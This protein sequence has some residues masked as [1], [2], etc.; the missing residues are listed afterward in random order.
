M[1]FHRSTNTLRSDFSIKWGLLL[2]LI[3]IL[4]S[5]Y[6]QVSPEE[7]KASLI[8][9]FCENV[10]WENIPDQEF[11]IGCYTEDTEIFR[12][13]NSAQNK[14]KIQGRNFSARMVTNP[15]QVDSCNALYYGKED[16]LL[17]TSIFRK[18]RE[19]NILLITDNYPDQLFVMIN[20][21]NEDDKIAFKVN[22]PNLSLAGFTVRPN[23][24]LN[25]G[26]VVDIK[27]AY[28]K[29]EEQLEASR[30]SFLYSQKAL[31]ENEEQLREKDSIIRQKE[32]AISKYL[33]EITFHQSESESLALQV[34]N[35][36]ALLELRTEEVSSKDR[37]LTRIYENIARSQE[38]LKH[39]N[40]NV[41]ILQ[42]AADTLK[43]EI[44]QKNIILTEKEQRISNQK[45]I[46][47]LFLGFS[48]T[49]A[50]AIFFMLRLF[51]INKRQNARLESAN[52]ELH[53]INTQLEEQKAKLNKALE[54]VKYA[55]MQMI[56]AEK[57]AS[58]GILTAGVAHEINNPLNFIQTGLYALE[59]SIL[60]DDQL[61]KESA[62]QI[63]N[64]L[65]KMNIGVQ[66]ASAIVKS[67]NTFNR[68]DTE[69][70]SR[71]NVHEMLDNTLLII[72]HEI[73]HKC[74]VVKNYAPRLPLIEGN[75]DNL[76]QV[77]LNIL[78]NGVQAIS[79]AGEIII[80]TRKNSDQVEISVRDNGVGI[81]EE[82]LKKIFDPFFTTKP[83]GKGVG[84]GLSICYKIIHEHQGNIQYASEP[85]KG[86]E[87]FISLP[88]RRLKK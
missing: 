8:V 63:R 37:E 57:M 54:D 67:L 85:G 72:N 75:A 52:K 18:A 7:I 62:G 29:F 25:G 70:M 30:Q 77:F 19:K 1:N 38:E 50:T 43:R 65:E 6:G 59:D 36:T 14:V 27:A 78:M 23:I 24:L 13:L 68:Q 42:S 47:L 22:M 12:I 80:T 66:R 87:V 39:V 79:E 28:E 64:I 10:S 58:L 81:S 82:N 49:L 4:N 84:L 73:K 34:Q 61:P 32:S 3:C 5:S 76:H 15:E 17:L 20:L 83:P 51:F 55:Q 46:I 40:E 9:H 35:E 33:E 71:F 86:T 2:L 44:N 16:P 26:S 11:V 48:A 21:I 88:V 45:K 53:V 74:Q 41:Y 69:T 60:D 31:A 56:Q